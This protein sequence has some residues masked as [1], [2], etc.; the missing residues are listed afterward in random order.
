MFM[1]PYDYVHTYITT[2]TYIIALEGQKRMNGNKKE[3]HSAGKNLIYI[4]KNF[5]F[6][7]LLSILTLVKA[8]VGHNGYNLGWIKKQ[9]FDI[10][11]TTTLTFFLKEYKIE[12]GSIF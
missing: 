4:L 10:F 3:K 6:S 5:F 9:N 12:F 7:C 11:G 1:C 2:L 8:V